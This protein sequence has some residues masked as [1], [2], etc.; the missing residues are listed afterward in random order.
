MQIEL[1]LFVV[2][3]GRTENYEQSKLLFAIASHTTQTEEGNLQQ[4]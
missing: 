4:T 2:L 1:V 3:T